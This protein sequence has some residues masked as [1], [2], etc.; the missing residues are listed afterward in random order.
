MDRAL[1]KQISLLWARRALSVRQ[2]ASLR[3]EKICT[4]RLFQK[5]DDFPFQELWPP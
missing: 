4:E 5:I 1:K 2:A 3:Q